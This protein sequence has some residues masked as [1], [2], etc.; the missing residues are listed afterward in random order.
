[1]RPAKENIQGTTS[2][3]PQPKTKHTFIVHYFIVLM[4]LIPR[5]IGA[6]FRN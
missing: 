4:L 5:L 3:V 1:M 2:P 6:A